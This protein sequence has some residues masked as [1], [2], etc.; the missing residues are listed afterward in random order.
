[1]Y[2]KKEY[3][4]SRKNRK[5][6]KKECK[7]ESKINRKMVI[8]I[9]IV[10]LIT[11]ALIYTAYSKYQSYKNQNLYSEAKPIAIETESNRQFSV[12]QLK[13][14]V[15]DLHATNDDVKAW[16]QIPNTEINYPMLQYSDND[17]YLHRDYNKDYTKYGS[18]YMNYKSDFSD[19][20]SNIIVY[21]HNMNDGQ[22][23]ATLNKYTEEEFYQEHSEF[24]IV[25]AE[26]VFIYEI[27]GVFNS[28]I[29]K[30][31]ETGVFRYYQYNN[32]ENESEFQE[33]IENIQSE[34]LFE[35][36]REP[37][38]GRQIMTL[39]TCRPGANNNRIVVVAQR[40]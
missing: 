35:S 1:M 32:L 24:Y 9:A 31:N 33:Y 3:D 19:V 36:G 13:E 5:K 39:S 37:E 20:N 26:E 38:Y 28:K 4:S 2:D 17:Y 25:T 15:A 16:I 14:T 7:E 22:M 12:E 8:N 23:F 11:I 21:G 40:K 27:F 34:Q 10:M 29:Y 30:E 18:I 6:R